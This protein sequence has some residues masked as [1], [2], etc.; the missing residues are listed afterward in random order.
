MFHMVT[1]IYQGKVVNGYF[2]NQA[3][4]EKSPKTDVLS[5]LKDRERAF[6]GGDCGK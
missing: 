2:I 5:A 1:R 6:G 4:G 3:K